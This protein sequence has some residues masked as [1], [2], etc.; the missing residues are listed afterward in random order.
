MLSLVLVLSLAATPAAP[1]LVS[2]PWTTSRVDPQLA[3]FYA[4]TLARAFRSQGVSISTPKDI[5]S[6]LGI[7]RT[8]QLLGCGDENNCMAELANALGC[9]ARLM[10]S[11]ARL[12]S[13]FTAIIKVVSANTGAVLAEE[14]AESSSERN[15]AYRL[16]DA[17]ERIAKQLTPPAPPRPVRAWAWLPLTVG[18][19]LLAGGGASIAGAYVEGAAIDQRVATTHLVNLQSVTDA[20]WGKV[21]Q[22][23][24]WIAAGVGVAALATGVVLLFFPEAK[25]APTVSLSPGQ[26]TLGFSVVMP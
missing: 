23:G 25:V 21:L 1:K 8:R 13:T 2:T 18:G 12:D 19:V 17:A 10:V 3:E 16:E 22:T 7:E 5:E 6:A 26:A 20:N 11:V 4:E 14:T 9:N 24:G 15:F